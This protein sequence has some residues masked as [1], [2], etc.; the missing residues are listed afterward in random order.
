MLDAPHHHVGMPLSDG[1][2]AE[3]GRLADET[4]RLVQVPGAVDG[5]RQFHVRLG[6]LFQQI[7][8]LIDVDEGAL[9]QG[10]LDPGGVHV[11]QLVGHD[12]LDVLLR[13]HEDRADEPRQVTGGFHHPRIVRLGE[14]H[15]GT[16]LHDLLDLVIQGRVDIVHCGRPPRDSPRWWFRLNPGYP[17]PGR[18]NSGQKSTSGQEPPG[19]MR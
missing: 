3:P 5:R 7:G 16:V 14:D 6:E 1:H 9:R 12:R 4:A 11:P 17:M 15:G 19:T 10:E 13:R 18:L 2:D 8:P